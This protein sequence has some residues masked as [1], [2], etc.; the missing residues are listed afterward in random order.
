MFFAGNFLLSWEH[1]VLFNVLLP[2]LC[3][4]GLSHVHCFL[5]FPLAVLLSPFRGRPR[6]PSVLC[7]WPHLARLLAVCLLM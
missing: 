4:V 2:Q 1:S 6:P 7:S 3:F 5:L